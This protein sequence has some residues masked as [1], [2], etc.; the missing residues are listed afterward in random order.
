MKTIVDVLALLV[1][2]ASVP[3]VFA[4]DEGNLWDNRGGEIR[5][6]T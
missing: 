2:F 4:A 1:M 3:F 5:S 6:A